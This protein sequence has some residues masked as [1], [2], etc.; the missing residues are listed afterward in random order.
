MCDITDNH[1]HY[2]DCIGILCSQRRLCM[3]PIHKLQRCQ[4]K[5]R[6]NH[7]DSLMCSDVKTHD[8]HNCFSTHCVVSTTW[9]VVMMFVWTLSVK[10]LDWWKLWSSSFWALETERGVDCYCVVMIFVWALKVK[11]DWEMC[12]LLS[13]E[14]SAL[15]EAGRRVDYRCV[16]TQRDTRLTPQWGTADWN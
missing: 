4:L 9:K 3:N 10:K 11:P 13:R 8:F 6:I 15:Y 16:N 12:G 1:Q 14:H 5:H 2:P 7:R